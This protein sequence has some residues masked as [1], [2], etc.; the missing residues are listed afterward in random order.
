MRELAA[1]VGQFTAGLAAQGIQRGDRVGLLM[2]NGLEAT[3]SLL[4]IVSLGAVVVPLFSGFGVD[5]IVARLSAA[6]AVAVIASTGFSRRTKRVNVGGR[7]A[8]RL[9]P[10]AHGA[11]RHLEALGR[12]GGCRTRATSTGRA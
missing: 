12:R 11:Q 2:A 9:A 3:I 1:Q 8:R 10:T 4:S 6:E 5:A 7:A